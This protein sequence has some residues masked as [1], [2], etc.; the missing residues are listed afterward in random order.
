MNPGYG[1]MNKQCIEQMQLKSADPQFPLRVGTMN[2]QCI[3]QMQL[4]RSVA[5]CDSTDVAMDEKC[6]GQMQLNPLEFVLTSQRW[7]WTKS[8]SDRCNPLA[9]LNHRHRATAQ[10]TKSASDR[11]NDQLVG[12]N[13]RNI[14][15]NGQ[16]VHRVDATSATSAPGRGLQRSNV[17]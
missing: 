3:E 9:L 5:R 12:D 15:D 10:S 7:Q 13:T 1:T 2:K 6:V 14:E 4:C 17:V 16:K 8:A 11:C